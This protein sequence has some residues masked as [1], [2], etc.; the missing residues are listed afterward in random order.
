LR[1][2]QFGKEL[3][4][5]E[6]DP[7]LRRATVFWRVGS[8]RPLSGCLVVRRPRE[9]P[10]KTDSVGIHFCDENGSLRCYAIS[11]QAIDV[12][13]GDL[14][15]RGAVCLDR[16]LECLDLSEASFQLCSVACVCLSY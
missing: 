5:Q 15:G 14:F 3:S 2:N 8:R 12:G 6:R 7:K 13:A 10:H 16:S 11:Q 9:H 4:R 1:P